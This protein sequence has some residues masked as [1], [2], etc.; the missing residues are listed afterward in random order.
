M[1]TMTPL[2]GPLGP[3]VAVVSFRLGCADGVSVEAAKWGR[4]FEALGFSVFTVAGAG[5]ADRPL[6]GPALAAPPPPSP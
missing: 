3:T 2:R 5:Q 1:D 6:S 4:A